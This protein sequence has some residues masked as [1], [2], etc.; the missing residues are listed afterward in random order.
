MSVLGAQR[1]E[2]R[3]VLGLGV[4]AL[5]A[6]VIVAAFPEHVPSTLLLIPVVLGSILLGPRTLPWFVVAQMAL[7]TIV[8]LGFV[9]VTSRIAGATAVQFAIDGIVLLAS[10]RRSRLGVAGMRGESMF[11]DLR[12]R[13]LGQG[14]LPALPRGWH[15]ESALSS[16]GGT[17]FAGDVIVAARTDEGRVL[18]VAVVDVSGKGEEAGTR[19]LLLSGALGG[20]LGALP[21]AQF[22]P[23]ANA[24]LLRQEWEEGFASAIHLWLHLDTGHLEVRLA[25]H[26]PAALRTAGSG[27]WQLLDGDGPLLGVVPDA[28]FVGHEGVLTPGDTL[29]LYTDGMVECRGRDIDLGLDRLLGEAE[30]TL[31]AG[32]PGAARRLAD[33]LGSRTDDRAVVVVHRR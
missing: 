29:V 21:P 1:R 32:V 10:F 15:A 26:P 20:L 33:V 30:S 8:I 11:V 9:D 24:F 5:V 2:T 7:L 22:L 19:A 16:A 28:D 23:A 12:D 6:A 17:A 25:G 27:R 3:L 14:E 18:Q 13:I 4:L 31:R